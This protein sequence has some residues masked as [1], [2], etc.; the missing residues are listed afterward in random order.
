MSA[1]NRV[2]VLIRDH[3]P[4]H[5][6]SYSGPYSKDGVISLDLLIKGKSNYVF[7]IDWKPGGTF[8]VTPTMRPL[9]SE[10]DMTPHHFPLGSI[11]EVAMHIV[12]LVSKT[13]GK[14]GFCA[15]AWLAIRAYVIIAVKYFMG[16]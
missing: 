13:P 8:T 12:D 7:H 9:N 3:L 11:H 14:V 4:R 10:M 6:V 16:K 5:M 15:R 1:L 2:V